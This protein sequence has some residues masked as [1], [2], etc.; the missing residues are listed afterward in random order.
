MSVLP[1]ESTLGVMDARTA[2]ANPPTFSSLERDLRGYLFSNDQGVDFVLPYLQDSNYG[3]SGIGLF[4]GSGGVISLSP[5]LGEG[6]VPFVIDKNK[7]VLEISALV[8][9]LVIKNS[10]PSEVFRQMP[11]IDKS[12]PITQD[13]NAE[14]WFRALVYGFLEDERNNYADYHWSNPDKYPEVRQALL[15]QPP[16]HVPAD[17]TDSK[18]SQWFSQINAGSDQSIVFANMTNVH[19]WIGYPMDFLQN[20]PFANDALIIYSSKPRPTLGGYPVFEFTYGIESYLSETKDLT[21][22]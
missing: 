12:H 1:G 10:T 11:T 5:Y 7:A 9:S 13:I 14:S 6:I 15:K 3:I 22:C 19:E 2:A 17:V 16:I 21:S 8:T 4:I 20:F 18:L